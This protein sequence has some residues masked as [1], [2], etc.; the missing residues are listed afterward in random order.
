MQYGTVSR[1]RKRAAKDEDL[2]QD[3]V[4]AALA[5][6]AR[7]GGIDNVRVEVLA[8][9]MGVTK[10]GFYRR[11]RDRRALLD[12]MLETWR[13]GRIAAIQRQV[14]EGGKTPIDR[15]RFLGKIYTE[16]A[17]EQGMAIELAIRQWARGDDAAAAAVTAVDGARLKASASQFQSA[18]HDVHRRKPA[19]TREPDRRLPQGI[20][21]H[22]NSR[23]VSPPHRAMFACQGSDS[24]AHLP[25]KADAEFF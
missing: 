6:L 8:E 4:A 23:A 17:N 19:Q 1:P 12:T 20:D 11:F 10:G 5:E 15:L 21:R 9:R 14:E 18:G 13:D 25:G 24:L 16:R 7:G 2:S 3:W 22:L